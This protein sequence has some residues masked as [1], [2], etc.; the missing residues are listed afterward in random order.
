VDANVV[1]DVV[2]RRQP[3]FAASNQILCLCRRKALVGAIA[4]HTVANLFYFYGKAVIPFVKERL[5]MDFAAHGASSAT[6]Q[7]V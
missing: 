6:I 5:V 7:D 3:H 2:G 4:F 1:F